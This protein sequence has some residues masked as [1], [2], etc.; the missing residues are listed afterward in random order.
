MYEFIRKLFP[1]H[2]KLACETFFNLCWRRLHNQKHSLCIV[3]W[4]SRS[5]FIVFHFH[6]I[7]VDPKLMV[8]KICPIIAKY[9]AVK[10]PT[11]W[12]IV[13]R[14]WNWNIYV[15]RKHCSFTP[16]FV[17]LTFVSIFSGHT[18]CYGLIIQISLL[19]ISFFYLQL[20][21]VL[22]GFGSKAFFFFEDTKAN[23]Q[24]KLKAS[25]I[26]NE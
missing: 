9:V 21:S 17:Y 20:S 2:N 15:Q 6:W 26:C 19:N 3:E 16:E 14:L 7:L 22:P 13:W 8:S 25:K 23:E 18:S 11:H 12:N 4:K 1:R 10:F 24:R 5:C